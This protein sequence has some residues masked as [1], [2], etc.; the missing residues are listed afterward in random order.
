M[1]YKVLKSHPYLMINQD[2]PVSPIP[3]VKKVKT[4]VRKI[5][6]HFMS[7]PYEL[8]ME[9]VRFVDFRDMCTLQRTSKLFNRISSENSIWK[10]LYCRHFNVTE[11]N[12]LEYGLVI[13][14]WQPRFKTQFSIYKTQF[15]QSEKVS[16][17]SSKPKPRFAHSGSSH[18]DSVYYIGGQMNEGRSDEIWAYDSKNSGFNKV[19]IANYDANRAVVQTDIS[20][21]CR[22]FEGVAGKVPSFA[23]HQSVTIGDKIYTFGGYD[24]TYFYNLSVFD[25]TAKTWSYPKV[26]GDVPIPR[27]N[28]ASAVV[29]TKFY[30]FGGSIG[31]NVD[32]YTVT[33]DFF[34]FDTITKIWKKIPVGDSDNE[35]SCRVGHV[36][37]AVDK[38]IYLFG[39]GVWG[40]E[41]GWTQQYNDLF[42]YSTVSGKWSRPSMKPEEKPSVCTYPFVFNAKQ[43]IF[44]FGGA[45]I[46]GATVTNKLYMW[47]I[48][49]AKWTEITINGDEISPRSIGTANV[50]GNEVILL[51]GYCGGLLQEDN[52][53]FKL[54]F[55]FPNVA[56]KCLGSS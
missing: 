56:L 24:Y 12:L 26:D 7:L 46:T 18:S 28:H 14:D 2:G 3:E 16:N 10:T 45:S 25:I 51:G 29:G 9:I 41:T 50:I 33:N 44:V 39:G 55:N 5:F 38:H 42:I 13:K 19:D 23:R 40:K 36:M 22:N 34:C 17:C 21:D 49:S 6:K 43:N 32:K 31:D 47:D 35:P 52:D 54:R 1:A 27:S 48:L 53:F 30:V 4:T 15:I 11:E 37:T 8:K 20:D